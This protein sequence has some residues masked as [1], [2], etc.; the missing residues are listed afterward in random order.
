ML[1]TG[2]N[3]TPGSVTAN[4]ETPAQSYTIPAGTF[5][6]IRRGSQIEIIP[7]VLHLRVGQALRIQNDDAEGGT[8]GPFYVG[9]HETVT[10]RFISTG[11]FQGECAVHPSGRIR[12]EVSN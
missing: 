11:D 10:Q 1:L 5:A 4:D 12:I 6:D 2:C 9:P 3:S 7:A 8:V